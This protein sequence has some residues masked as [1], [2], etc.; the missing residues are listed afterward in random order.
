M[1]NDSAQFKGK[2]FADTIKSPR[3][4][5]VCVLIVHLNISVCFIK[6]FR[7]L[8]LVLHRNNASQR[9]F[10]LSSSGNGILPAGETNNF[11]N[12][13]NIGDNAFDNN[14]C[15]GVLQ[16]VEKLRQ[17]IPALI[18]FI[19]RNNLALCLRRIMG[20]LKQMLQE[21]NAGDKSL[22]VFFTKLLKTFP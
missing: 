11:D 7:I 16:P 8:Y 14:R 4:D 1:R 13:V 21:F 17:S 20:Q 3:F 2:I 15:V 6:N 5:S 12:V 10:D 18:N 9:P 22:L 19:G